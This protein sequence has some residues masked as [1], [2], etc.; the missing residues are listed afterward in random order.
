MQ[1][2]LSHITCMVSIPHFFNSSL[3]SRLDAVPIP[4]TL[5]RR[6]VRIWP[7]TVYMDPGL[8][9]ITGFI[10]HGLS[11]SPSHFGGT[12]CR[13]AECEETGIHPGVPIH[14]ALSRGEYF[15]AA[16]EHARLEEDQIGVI[17]RF[18]AVRSMS[19]LEDGSTPDNTRLEIQLNTNCGRTVYFGVRKFRDQHL[20]AENA[21]HNSSRLNCGHIGAMGTPR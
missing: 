10:A 19:S 13:E 16:W 2:S 1:H 17:S 12:K 3:L 7:D 15:T 20:V 6:G 4:T 9:K 18:L 21:V 5:L 8:W 14:F 11:E